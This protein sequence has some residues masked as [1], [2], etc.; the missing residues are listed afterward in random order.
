MQGDG[1][2]SFQGRS[3]LKFPDFHNFGIYGGGID[4]LEKPCIMKIMPKFIKVS[5]CVLLSFSVAF[6]IFAPFIDTIACDD[7]KSPLEQQL[8]NTVH[9]CSFCSS[10]IGIVSCRIPDAPLLSM[11]IETESPLIAYSGPVFFIEKPP[12]G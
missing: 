2:L 10:A 3:F 5:K 4:L 11:P 7:C 9:L 6:F 8:S 12:R 1:T